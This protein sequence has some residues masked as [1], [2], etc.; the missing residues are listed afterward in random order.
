M[1]HIL[2]YCTKISKPFF[3]AVIR[4]YVIKENTKSHYYKFFEFLKMFHLN[5]L[6]YQKKNRRICF[7]LQKMFLKKYR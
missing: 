7:Y 3:Y 6:K 1:S 5:I 4:K 2:E